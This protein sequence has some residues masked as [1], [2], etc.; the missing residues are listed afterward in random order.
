MS[1]LESYVAHVWEA[2][3]LALGF[4]PEAAR[5]V[6][7]EPES[8]AV[9][10]SVAF[11]AGLSLLLGQSVVL[12]LNRVSKA[13]FA[14]TLTL[15]AVI[16][17]INLAIWSLVI[18]FVATFA[19]GADRPIGIGALAILLGSAPFVFGFFILIPYL[20]I[21][22]TRIL[23]GWSFLIT[24]VMVQAVFAIGWWQALVSVG[25]G[26]VLLLI[27]NR[28]VGRPV[29]IIRDRIFRRLTGLQPYG[30][31]NAPES[32]GRPTRRIGMRSE[33]KLLRRR[34]MRSE[35]TAARRG[36]GS[37]ELDVRNEQ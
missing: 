10:L 28:T 34:M 14:I 33:V 36:A 3:W 19:F 6:S 17:V 31:S 2:I 1:S 13:R 12:F 11:L 5:F 24:L 30:P 26:W 20:G 16:Y 15:N 21:I 9:V 23:Y 25:L 22:L 27:L 37:Q 7:T 35:A 18:W 32:R 8:I 29:V 4:N